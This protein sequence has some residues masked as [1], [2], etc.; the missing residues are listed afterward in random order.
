MAK[1]STNLY[2]LDQQATDAGYSTSAAKSAGPFVRKI[3]VAAAIDMYVKKKMT[4]PE[5]AKHFNVTSPAVYQCLKRN[6]VLPISAN[7]KRGRPGLGPA[8]KMWIRRLRNEGLSQRAIAAKLGVHVETVR[9]HLKKCGMNG[10][11]TT[12]VKKQQTKRK[13]VPAKATI[14]YVS[15]PWYRRVIDWFKG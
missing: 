14:T 4:G 3:D 15:R 6:G 13:A 10:P 9:K 5:I 7:S 8:K 2:S 11:V 12:V 1:Q